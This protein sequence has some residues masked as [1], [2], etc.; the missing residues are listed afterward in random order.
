VGPAHVSVLLEEVMEFLQVAPHR[1]YLDATVGAGGHAAEILRRTEPDG[2][3]VGIDRD[4]EALAEARGALEAFGERARLVHGNFADLPE[5]LK[6]LGIEDVDGILFDLGV[7]SMQFDRPG[8]GFSFREDGPLDMRMDRSRGPTAADL[9]QTLSEAEL[10]EIL[11]TFGE[12]RWSRRIARAL[13]TVREGEPVETTGA[14]KKIVYRAVPKR[15]QSRHL[16]PATRT[17]Q[18]L[19]IAVNR[20][21]ECLR[22][23]LEAAW[24]FLKRGG[25]LC[26]ISFHSLEDRIVKE[27]FRALS[28]KPS[29][30]GEK[31]RVLEVITRKPVSPSEG[32]V[33]RN[34]RSRSAKLRC[35]ERC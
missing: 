10:S 30:P 34:P 5:I 28:R 2:K 32:E 8:R 14:L 20:E 24:P 31:E 16:D 4:E 3:V 7:S 21:L 25:R 12:E 17:F 19:R 23:A 9:L 6:S 1:V 15:F 26:V 29:A 35:A 22:S 18:A 11:W 27:T 13:V 33:D